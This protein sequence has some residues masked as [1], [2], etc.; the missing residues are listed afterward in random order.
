MLIYAAPLIVWSIL[1]IMQKILESHPTKTN[2]I[3]SVFVVLLLVQMIAEY[4]TRFIL[5]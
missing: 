3:L 1:R 4:I 5:S 2:L